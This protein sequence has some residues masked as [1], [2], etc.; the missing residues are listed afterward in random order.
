[1]RQNLTWIFGLQAAVIAG[2]FAIF[3]ISY[4][5][6][7][8]QMAH[9]NQCSVVKSWLHRSPKLGA[10]GTAPWPDLAYARPAGADCRVSTPP[11][12]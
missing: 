6:G 9:A 3:A 8:P 7:S 1:M 12:S 4:A 2:L 11:G 5:I 10:D